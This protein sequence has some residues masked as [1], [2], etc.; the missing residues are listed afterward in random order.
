MLKEVHKSIGSQE[1]WAA[2]RSFQSEWA[3]YHANCQNFLKPDL[4]LLPS[5]KQSTQAEGPLVW[6]F[7]VGWEE[8]KENNQSL[9][10]MGKQ[11][12]FPKSWKALEAEVLIDLGYVLV[13][14]WTEGPV[15]L[16]LR[17]RIQSWGLAPSSLGAAASSG[18]GRDK[19]W[20]SN[21]LKKGNLNSTSLFLRSFFFPHLSSSPM[22]LDHK[23]KSESQA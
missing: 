21:K 13:K 2:M 16:S 9:E 11:Q 7:L 15:S 3:H 4:F 10:E 12:I 5:F 1:K 17:N 8:I 14:H 20:C 23:W 18:C 6:L 19:Y 22:R